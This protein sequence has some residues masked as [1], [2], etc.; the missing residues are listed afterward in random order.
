MTLQ[1][2]LSKFVEGYPLPNKEPKT[3][4]NAFIENDILRY[5]TPDNTVSD[6]GAKFLAL[7]LTE[8]CKILQIKNLPLSTYHHKTLS[9]LK[10]S[11]KCLG[12]YLRMQIAKHSN[13]WVPRCHFGAWYS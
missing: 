4:A 10:N 2:E 9:S 3:V 12:A 1:C 11:Y 13:T 5:G 7:F 6:Q 8:V